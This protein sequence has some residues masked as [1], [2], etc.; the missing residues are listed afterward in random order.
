M[1]YWNWGK[2]LLSYFC[3]VREHSYL[4]S[5]W[6]LRHYCFGWDPTFRPHFLRFGNLSSG[7]MTT[8]SIWT[9]SLSYLL[10]MWWCGFSPEP[11]VECTLSHSHQAAAMPMWD[12]ICQLK[13]HNNMKCVATKIKLG[14]RSPGSKSL[15]PNLFHVDPGINQLIFFSSES[16][17]PHP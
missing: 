17:W 5:P 10:S 14:V 4:G 13:I 1:L 15:L 8:W 2:K 9:D 16:Q 12:Y 3:L 7:L 11:Q 6:L